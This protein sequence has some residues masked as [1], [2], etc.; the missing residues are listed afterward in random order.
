VEEMDFNTQ[1]KI[2]IKTGDVYFGYKQTLKASKTGIAKLLILSSNCPLSFKKEIQNISALSNL[3]IYNFDRSSI[4]L[5]LACGK[6]FPVSIL[7][8]KNPGD[9]DILKIGEK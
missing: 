1:L 6:R 9:S 5:G 4:D 7:A 8:I 3:P 2:A